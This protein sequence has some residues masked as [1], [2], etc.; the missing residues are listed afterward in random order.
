MKKIIF[1][2]RFFFF[3]FPATSSFSILVVKYRWEEYQTGNTIFAY[4]KIW[5]KFDLPLALLP[6]HKTDQTQL[7]LPSCIAAFLKPPGFLWEANLNTPADITN[8]AQKYPSQ[9]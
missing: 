2:S 8:R 3:F 7:T 4:F 9:K 6:P 5:N 1:Y